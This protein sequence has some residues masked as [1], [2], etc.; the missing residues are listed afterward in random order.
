MSV[1][2]LIITPYRAA[3]AQDRGSVQPSHKHSHTRHTYNGKSSYVPGLA[4]ANLPG[5]LPLHL[6]RAATTLELSRPCLIDSP[7]SF[8]VPRTTT[9]LPPSRRADHRS[10]L[11]SDAAAG[12]VASLFVAG[13]RALAK[14]WRS[15]S[16]FIQPLFAVLQ[17]SLPWLCPSL[18]SAFIVAQ[19]LRN[20]ERRFPSSNRHLAELSIL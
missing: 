8:F 19:A 5:R 13:E 17:T 14:L 15:L 9:A 20:L 16:S 11:F 6:H 1:E 18:S 12:E 4:R 7:R 3:Q 2:G 10:P